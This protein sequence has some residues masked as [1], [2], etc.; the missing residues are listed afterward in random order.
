MLGIYYLASLRC[1]GPNLRCQRL[2]DS[3]QRC[4]QYEELPIIAKAVSE[5]DKNKRKEKR[6]LVVILKF[7]GTVCCERFINYTAAYT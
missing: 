1:L 6:S 5:P 3:G 2:R 7:L 4:H